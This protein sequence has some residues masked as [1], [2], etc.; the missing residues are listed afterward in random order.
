MHQKSYLFYL[1][2]LVHLLSLSLGDSVLA[3]EL[4]ERTENLIAQ[5]NSALDIAL[6]PYLA[7]LKGKRILLSTGGVKSWSLILAAQDLGMEVIAVT[8]GKTTEEEKAKI[9]QYLS[10]DGM[11]LADTTPQAILKV[12]NQTKADILITGA[13]NKYTALKTRIPFL[14]INH[15]R[16][17]A[18]A[19]YA[20]LVVLASELHEALYSPIWE[21]ISKTAPWDEKISYQL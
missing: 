21:Q 15:E 6:A 12:L 2:L 11:L 5:E 8:D 4:Q 19:G 3:H 17:H 13:G 16:H 7:D 9:Q 14:Y 1:K 20:G 18:Y 10:A